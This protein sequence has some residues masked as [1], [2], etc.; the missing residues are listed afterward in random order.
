[1]PVETIDVH[2]FCTQK[3]HSLP[4]V[5]TRAVKLSSRLSATSPPP[6]ATTRCPPPPPGMADTSSRPSPMSGSL[7]SSSATP[8][9]S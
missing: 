3:T 6:V 8:V 2:I 7:S 5:Q 1:M 4:T 9:V